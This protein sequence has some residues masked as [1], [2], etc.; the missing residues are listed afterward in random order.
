MKAYALIFCRL[1]YVGSVGLFR[2]LT[3]TKTDMIFQIDEPPEGAP[4]ADGLAFITVHVAV[5][6]LKP[7]GGIQQSCV[8]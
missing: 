7:R 8:C 4:E 6:T 2:T 5:G 1:D 3:H